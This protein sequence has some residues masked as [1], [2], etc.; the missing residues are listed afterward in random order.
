MRWEIKLQGREGTWGKSIEL[1]RSR[2]LMWTTLSLSEKGVV[3][4]ESKQGSA[5][6]RLAGLPGFKWC[7]GIGGGG[8]YCEPHAYPQP[9]EW[10]DFLTWVFNEVNRAGV[11]C[12]DIC[13]WAALSSSLNDVE[14]LYGLTISDKSFSRVLGWGE[15]REEIEIVGLLVWDVQWKL[16]WPSG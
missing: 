12:M 3:L 10:R 1:W 6:I 9:R 13:L 14:Y 5:G 7:Q 16:S 15:Q 4:Q 8:N 2:V 11:A